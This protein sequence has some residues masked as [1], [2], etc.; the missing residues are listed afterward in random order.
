M[1]FQID[2]NPSVLFLT[3]LPVLVLECCVHLLLEL[4]LV[5]M[6][7]DVRQFLGNFDD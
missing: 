4:V 5:P 7:L 2:L 1:T 6:T 3:W